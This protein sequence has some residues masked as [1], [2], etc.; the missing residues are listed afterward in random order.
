L[1]LDTLFW[2][3]QLNYT[4]RYIPSFYQLL[5]EQ[6]GYKVSS[7]KIIWLLKTAEYIMYDCENLT[8]ELL[9]ELNKE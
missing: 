4:C 7:R 5:F 1:L 2:Q 8:K 9:Q 3:I 6:T